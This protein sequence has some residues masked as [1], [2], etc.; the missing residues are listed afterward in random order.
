[1][2]P[3]AGVSA[4]HQSA[5]E[6]GQT[7]ILLLPGIDNPLGAETIDSNFRII[8]GLGGQVSAR[9]ANSRG[10]DKGIS[11]LGELGDGLLSNIRAKASNFG[12]ASSQA[13]G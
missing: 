11:V 5:S 6:N 7:N 12:K 3:R 13:R 10:R 9:A 1:M 8:F 2:L 4:V